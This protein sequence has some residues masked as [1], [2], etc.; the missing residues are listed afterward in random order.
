MFL[1]LLVGRTVFDWRFLLTQLSV[2]RLHAPASRPCKILCQE[3]SPNEIRLA[4]EIHFLFEIKKDNNA[5]SEGDTRL[6]LSMIR[7]TAS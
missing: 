6:L 1:R 5:L 7:K 3:I 2:A 4:A